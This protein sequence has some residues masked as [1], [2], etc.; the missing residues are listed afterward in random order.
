MKRVN[1]NKLRNLNPRCKFVKGNSNIIIIRYTYT[2]Y[3]EASGAAKR[4]KI[5][6][7]CTRDK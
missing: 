7:G 3:A 5:I 2:I 4:Q 1:T 6:E